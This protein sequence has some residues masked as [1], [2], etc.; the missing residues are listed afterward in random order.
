MANNYRQASFTFKATAEQ[1]AWLLYV[2]ES[3]SLARDEPSEPRD[4]EIAALYDQLMD[5]GQPYS[6]NITQ[7][8]FPAGD[9]VWIRDYGEYIDID[10]TAKLIQVWLKHF[11]INEPV[12]FEWADTC[13][14]SR[15][16]E[17]GGGAVIVTQD[18]IHIMSTGQWIN[19]HL[20][21]LSVPAA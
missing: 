1:A 16:D 5:E 20:T 21:A 3:I 9:E 4:P 10:Y 19:E 6:L 8:R 12:A 18:R 7:E 2:H 14:R 13:S 11:D 15:P 17:F